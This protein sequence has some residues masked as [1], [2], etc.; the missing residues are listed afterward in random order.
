MNST[1]R[2]AISLVCGLS[3]I[4]CA[5]TKDE[6][7][8]EAKGGTSVSPAGT[9]A[10]GPSTKGTVPAIPSSATAN[11]AGAKGTGNAAL[12]ASIHCWSLTQT[13]YFQHVALAEQTGNLPKPPDKVHGAWA[14]HGALIA[15]KS[16]LKLK[17]LEDA[18]SK[19]SRSNKIYSLT[20]DDDYAKSVQTCIDT[21]PA[22]TNEPDPSWPD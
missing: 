12:D 22:P 17:E 6:A 21:V 2:I 16:G 20:V 10:K 7:K 4:G 19:A 3:L 9:N 13:A 14:K 8:D 18:K 1:Q 5:K 11:E 15:F